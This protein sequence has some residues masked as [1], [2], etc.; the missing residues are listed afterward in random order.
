VYITALLGAISNVN[1]AGITTPSFD[2]ILF[3]GVV[4]A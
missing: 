3:T 1:P 2:F 4:S